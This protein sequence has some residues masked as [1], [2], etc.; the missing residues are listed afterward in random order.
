MIITKKDYFLAFVQWFYLTIISF[1]GVIAGLVLY[2]FVFVPCIL[3][4]YKILKK[5]STPNR[6]GKFQQKHDS[7]YIQNGSSKLWNY[8]SLDSK[9]AWPWMN[10]EDGSLGELSGK[11]SAR[12]NG[13]ERS[14][15]AII[16]WFIRNPFNN[17]KRYWDVMN[18]RPNECS[19]SWIG[20]GVRDEKGRPVITDTKKG[21]DGWYFVKCVNKKT[22]RKYYGFR[23]V[24]C[25]KNDKV[26]H[27]ILGFKIRPSHSDLIVVPD[28]MDK[29]VTFRV[30]AWA[31]LG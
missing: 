28:D 14:Y 29:G 2:P 11:H 1:T 10:G 21:Y 8:W 5:P 17:A 25:R 9:I 16:G 7:D 13:K 30:T 18:C 15:I 6:F 19:L 23:F 4:K 12:W 31:N 26:I 3:I 24:K 20:E 22:G 27:I